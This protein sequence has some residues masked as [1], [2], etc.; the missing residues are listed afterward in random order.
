M[1]TQGLSLNTIP[2]IMIPLRFFLTAPLFGILAALLVLF[3]GPE[4]WVSRWLA[5][6]LALTHLLTI[7][8]MLMIMIGA[9][10]QFIPV[11]IGQLIPGS[12][13]FA[14]IIHYLLLIG[15]IALAFSFLTGLQILYWVALISLAGAILLFA[16]SLVPLLISRL[17]NQLIVYL[18][19]ILYSV[20]FV[21]IGLG[22]FMLLAYSLPDSGIAFRKYT[23]IHAVWGLIGWVVLLIMAVSSQVIPMF[24]VTP[25]FSVKYLKL[26]SLLMFAT[27]IIISFVNSDYRI[28][29]ELVFTIELVFFAIVTLR[30]INQRK[31]KLPDVTIN[32]FRLSLISLLMAISLWWLWAQ[33]PDLFPTQASVEFS[34]AILLIYGLALSAIIGML[35]KIVPFLVFLHLQR[36]SFS[37]P[38]SMAHI[39]NMKQVITTR[40]SQ[41]QLL[42]HLLSLIL[43]LVSVYVPAMVWL[44]GIIMLGSFIWL[45]FCLMQG[46]KLFRYNQSQILTYPEIKFNF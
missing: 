25:E 22:L 29:V 12:K 32:F 40:H 20:M 31:R 4:I 14:P 36:L 39:P 2:P 41:V 27:L 23:N 8:F 43:L 11:M 18:L 19:R 35:Q 16:G 33:W 44:S 30:L 28:Y 34:L 6:S 10:Y 46:I 3:S 13:Q 9:L 42:L 38:D 5:S 7:G 21:T 37:R 15:T 24:F 45:F 17:N 26:L 1:N